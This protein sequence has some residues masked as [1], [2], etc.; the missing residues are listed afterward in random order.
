MLKFDVSKFA[1][2]HISAATVSLYNYCSATCSTSGAATVA[3]RITSSWSSSSIAWGAQSSATTTGMASSTG[4]W[5]DSTCSVNWSNWRLQSI[6]QAWADGYG[7]QIRGE[8][9]TDSTTWR[10]FRSA[11]YTTAGYAPK[12]VVTYNSYAT[13][14]PLAISPSTVNAYS[15]KRYVATCTPTLSA[16]VTDADGSTVKGQFEII[17]DPAYP[18]TTYSYTGTSASVASGST[19][20]LIIPSASQLAAVHLRMR[21]RG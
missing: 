16:K 15:G 12:L 13:T 4:H 10:R 18:D 7:L 14:S 11:N 5:G 19:A 2:N 8:S 20:K 6:V 1:G 3:T 9:E 17:N 21:V